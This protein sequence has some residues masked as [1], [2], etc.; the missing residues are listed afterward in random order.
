MVND[1]PVYPAVMINTLYASSLTSGTPFVPCIRMADTMVSL[2]IITC[3][4][5]DV[6]GNLA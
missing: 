2:V 4:R 1:K 6:A 3:K 5:T